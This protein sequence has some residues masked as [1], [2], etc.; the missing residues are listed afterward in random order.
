MLF[1][2][3]SEGYPGWQPNTDS[4][5]LKVSK[6]VYKDLYGKT[7]GVKAIHAGLEC[8]LFLQKYP[9]LDMISFGPDIRD[10]HSPVERMNI[11]SVERFWNYLVGIL[12]KI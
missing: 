8:G 3:H 11:P 4:K 6:E 10:A 7:P 9:N 2:S 1:R 12:D 5:I